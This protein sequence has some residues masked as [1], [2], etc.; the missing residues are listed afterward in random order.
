MTNSCQFRLYFRNKIIHVRMKRSSVVI[1]V[2]A[3]G[4]SIYKKTQTGGRIFSMKYS[5]PSK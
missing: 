1:N 5:L 3:R 4:S 2:P